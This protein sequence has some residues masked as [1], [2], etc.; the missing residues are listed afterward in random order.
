MNKK[1]ATFLLILLYTIFLHPGLYSDPG[2]LQA[3]QDYGDA[4]KKFE[5]YVEKKMQS[6]RIPG[7]SIGFM[8]DDF[9]W[10]RGFGYSDLENKVKAK[11][12]PQSSYRMASVSKTFTAIAV[13]KLA[14]DGKIDLDEEVQTY[15]PD[16]P[17]K[18]WPVTV[19]QLLGHLGGISHYKDYDKECH[20]KH[21][22]NTEEALSK[23]ACDRTPASGPSWRNQPLQR[24]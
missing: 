2:T 9:T 23:V 14:E 3:L 10:V 15:V 13:L 1:T 7:L 22:M 16:F 19:R 12:K 11:P 18:K 8:K 20:F 5:Q 6:D 21:H 24:L 17:K 4:I